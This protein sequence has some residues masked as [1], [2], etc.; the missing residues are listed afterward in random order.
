MEIAG[1]RMR[2]ATFPLVMAFLALVSACGRGSGSAPAAQASAAPA[3]GSTDP[4]AQIFVVKGCPQCH[5]IGA[6]GV[7]SLTEVGP[8][9]TLAY[10]DVG[11]RFGVKLEEFLKN[12][13]GTMMVVLNSQIQLSETERDSIIHILKELAEHKGDKY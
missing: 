4:R 8:D 13:T 7:K 12:P 10:E 6:L 3:S 1:I 2:T 11:S 9:L 5:S